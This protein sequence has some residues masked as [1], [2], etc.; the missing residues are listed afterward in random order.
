MYL[1]LHS[2]KRFLVTAFQWP[3]WALFL[4][5]DDFLALQCY[6]HLHLYALVSWHSHYSSKLSENRVSTGRAHPAKIKWRQQVVKT[7]P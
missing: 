5:E 1:E 6:L 2:Y 7:R 4:V 3:V